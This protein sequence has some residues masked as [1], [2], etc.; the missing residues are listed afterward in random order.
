[1]TVDEKA[2]WIAYQTEILALL[3]EFSN[4]RPNMTD[5]EFIETLGMQ[6]L[7]CRE[8]LREAMHE[9]GEADAMIARQQDALD[10]CRPYVPANIWQDALARIGTDTAPE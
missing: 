3:L 9:C 10:L 5:A 4:R 6:L 7:H 8:A 2:E 1:M